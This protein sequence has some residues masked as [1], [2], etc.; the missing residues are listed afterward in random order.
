MRAAGGGGPYGGGG[1][2][3]AILR[4]FGGI[5]GMGRTESSAPTGFC[6]RRAGRFSG[7][8]AASRFPDPSGHENRAAALRRT[9]FIRHRRRCVRTPPHPSRP[10]AVTP[11]PQ[12]EGGAEQRQRCFSCR[13]RGE[14]GTGHTKKR[15]R[16]V[17][18]DRFMR[19]FER[20]CYR[21]LGSVQR[22]YSTRMTLA[23]VWRP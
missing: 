17:G 20:G 14:G 2:D 1:S 5:G 3:L 13:P 11:S 10:L 8:V 15:S 4:G 18:R 12:G 9:C 22:S 7:L 6:A 19:L 16:L 23:T 21:A